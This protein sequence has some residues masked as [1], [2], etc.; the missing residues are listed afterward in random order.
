M[1]ST[2]I[3]DTAY[4]LRARI[5]T[6]VGGAG[7]IHIGP[8]I[9]SELGGK[10]ISIHL[11]HLQV[12]AELRNQKRMSS[13]PDTAPADSLAVMR[14]ALPLDLRFLIT[15]LRDNPAN[16]DPDELT[17][18][19]QIL[20]VLHRQ[21][22]L[23]G[24][25]MGGQAVRITPEPYPMEEIS[26]IWGLF[27]QDVYRTSVVYLASPVWVEAQNVAAGAAVTEHRHRAGLREDA[28]PIPGISDET[29]GRP[30]A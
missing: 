28:P 5:G 12:N 1:S 10:K 22:T 16:A 30:H 27:P 3:F 4:A 18:L 7:Q 15:V 19:G 13:P 20:Q 11:F 17:T 14:D 8:P 21:P 29:D 26:R 25:E 2:A 6:A 23:A 24:E 9:S